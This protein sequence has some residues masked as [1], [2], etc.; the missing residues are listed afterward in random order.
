MIIHPAKFSREGGR[1][2]LSTTVEIETSGR[3]F[4]KTGQRTQDLWI[5]WPESYFTPSSESVDPFFLICLPLAMR[6]NERLKVENDISQ[7][8][9]INSLE[10]MA[11]YEHYFPKYCK[12]VELEARGQYRARPDTARVGSFYS[13][14]VDSLYNI[15]E[16]L[17]L[18]HEFGTLPVTD[19]WLIQGMDISL[20]QAD[21]WEKTKATIFGHL[22]SEDRL[23][24]ADIRTNARDLHHGI[25]GWERLGF[26]VILGGVAKCFAPMVPNALI[27]SYAKYDDILPHASSPLVDPMWSCD[28]QTVRHFSCRANRQEKVETVARY[29]PYLLKGLRVCYK[30]TGGAYNCGTCEKCM[31]T[32]LQLLLGGY[33]ELAKTFD[34]EISAEALRRLKL[35]WKRKNGYT[36]DFWQKIRADLGAIGEIELEKSLVL[37]MRRNSVKR[38]IMRFVTRK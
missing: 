15:A 32:Q 16:C 1:H 21:L 25:V 27:G 35:P 23:N 14:G 36:W 12:V 5:D 3:T 7:A 31:R 22:R 38:S 9:L 6:M 34:Q 26:S 11:I 19:L 13:G 24:F 20:E 8:L 37:S 30:N 28:E 29:A 17:R 33:Q 10:A 2:R 18:Q 4:P